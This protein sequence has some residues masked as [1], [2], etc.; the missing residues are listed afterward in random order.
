MERWPGWVDLGDWLYTEIHFPHQEFNPEHGHPSQRQLGPA[1]INF[2]DRDQR[3]DHNAHLSAKSS[4][5]I[6]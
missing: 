1:E 6:Q 5:I 4:I 3:I 2:I